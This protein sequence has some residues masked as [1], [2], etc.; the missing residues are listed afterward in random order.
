MIKCKYSTEPS[1]FFL[2]EK[3]YNKDLE[4]TPCRPRPNF[5]CVKTS[6]NPD[7]IKFFMNIIEQVRKFVESECK[8]P[9][10][11]YGYDP[12]LYH[13]I[14]VVE[15]SEKLAGKL[16][17]EKEIVIIAA[18]LHD[19]GS[20]IHGRKDHH[21]TS[22]KIAEEKLSEFGYTAE[23]I[24]KVRDC[25]ISHRGSQQISPK[26]LEA[27]I[28]IEADTLSAFNDIT[29]LFQS[30]LVYEKLSRKEAKDSVKKKLINKWK[31]LNLDESR[32]IIKS[33]YK[34]VML[35]LE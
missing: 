5:H 6:L 35:L 19:I 3:T 17:A 14:P 18:W 26:T 11:N 33:K 24:E 12:F 4:T 29:G 34:A 32:E 8:K 25:I 16:G 21:I 23:K 30:A 27:K 31:Q 9:S 1:A 13:F 22:A 2:A 10:S 28:L 15:Y 20:I 7:V